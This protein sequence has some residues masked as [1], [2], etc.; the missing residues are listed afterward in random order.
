M[1]ICSCRNV[2]DKDVKTYLEDKAEEKVRPREIKDSC[3][4]QSCAKEC[5]SCAPDFACFAKNHNAEVTV[6]DL[7][8]ALPVRKK[9]RVPA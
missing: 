3:A 5:H 6:R 9:G 2:S 8:K 1:I 4:R 7:G